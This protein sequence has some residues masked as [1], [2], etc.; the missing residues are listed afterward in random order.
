MA[1]NLSGC[2]SFL[3]YLIG[4]NLKSKML[5]FGMKMYKMKIECTYAFALNK[6]N[7]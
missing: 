2:L 6:R 7:E 5:P 3:Y 4:S 1:G